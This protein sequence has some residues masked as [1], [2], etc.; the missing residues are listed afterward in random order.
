MLSHEIS[1]GVQVGLDTNG[2][3]KRKFIYLCCGAFGWEFGN[4]IDGLWG[5]LMRSIA[6]SLEDL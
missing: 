6:A 4:H 2:Y 3:Y 1:Q 5:V